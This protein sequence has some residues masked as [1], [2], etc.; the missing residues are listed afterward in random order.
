MGN[1]INWRKISACN[2]CRNY[3]EKTSFCHE[4][5]KELNIYE[6][7]KGCEEIY[8][9]GPLKLELYR[10]MPKDSILRELSIEQ[11]SEANP[12]LKNNLNSQVYGDFFVKSKTV[13]ATLNLSKSEKQGRI[14][15]LERL[16]KAQ[17]E[18]QNKRTINQIIN[19]TKSF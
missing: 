13:N 8:F 15:S 11:I 4:Q 18:F 5:K 2:Y 10:E 6:E 14:I 7:L 17:K 1:E 3:D 9:V 12:E 16:K 19:N